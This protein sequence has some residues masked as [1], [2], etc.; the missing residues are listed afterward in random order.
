MSTPSAFVAPCVRP[1]VRRLARC[2]AGVLLF[3]VT[4]ASA[5]AQTGDA[6]EAEPASPTFDRG[7]SIGHWLA[8]VDEAVGYGTDWFGPE[9]VRWI[10]AQGFD[11]VRYP[12][13]G[14]LWRND[15][16]SLRE[17]RI[18]PF[19]DALR[20]T[21]EAGLSTVL[22]MH[23]LPGGTYDPNT[24]DERRFTDPAE[25]AVAADFIRRV[26]LRF[27]DEGPALRIEL[28]NEPT[29][30]S[31]AD[32]NR[33]Y[34]SLVEAVRTVDASRVLYISSNR[35]GSFE[36]LREV[37]FPDDPHVALLLHYDEPS[38]FTHQRTPWKGY[39]DEMP[40]VPFP[41]VVPDLAPYLPADHEAVA[42][43]GTTLTVGQVEDDFAAATAWVQAQAPGIEM[44]VGGFGAY[45]RAP[46]ASRQAY[47]R[48][49]REAAEANGWGWCVWDYKSSF[50]VRTADGDT[51]AVLAG[52]FDR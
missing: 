20:W 9:D 1:L 13:D 10:A 33:L 36:T 8:K 42:A 12:V 4:A 29:A 43:S 34:G 51:T 35:S 48:A 39:P 31:S 50:G 45:E 30:P 22:D 18:A 44:Y 7:I 37:A 3:A 47:I 28:L 25:A 38:V 6:P 15:D 5:L 40:P 11:H 27:Q 17:D 14:R 21:T 24:Q 41:G 23:F 32:L 52:L 26:A 19:A 46:D 49:V 2:G 16:G